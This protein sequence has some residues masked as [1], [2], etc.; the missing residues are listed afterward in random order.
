M[1]VV[2]PPSSTEPAEPPAPVEAAAGRG[3]AV[4]VAAGILSSRLIGLVRNMVLSHYFGA[5]AHADVLT[6][7]MR[8]PNFLQ[9]LLGEGTLSAAFIPIYSRLLHEGKRE[10]AGRFAGAIFGLLCAT[11]G[12]LA[13]LGVLL[14][15]PI[16]T[17]LAFGFKGDAGAV[18]RFELTVQ[19]VRIIFPMTMFLVLSAWALGVLNSH[20][21][22]FL[23]YFAPVVWNGAIIAALVWAGYQ[24]APLDRLLFA[25]CWG[26]LAGG[27]LQLLVQL[28]TALRLLRSF[29]PSLSPRVPGVKEALGAFGPVLAGRGVVQLA[30]YVDLFLASFLA[31][32]AIAALG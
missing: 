27:A 5:G 14:A 3:G 23:P 25:A 22:F 16:T 6:V 12:A 26:A 13:L 2:D 9:N 1:T 18:D 29:R 11:A 30:G 20:R 32:G 8:A 17:V 24:D 10:E 21:R 31:A 28:P 19:A 7:A 15:R 4:L